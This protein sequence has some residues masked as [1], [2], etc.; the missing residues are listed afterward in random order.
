M[1]K[2]RLQNKKSDLVLSGELNLLTGLADKYVTFFQVYLQ[3]LF[4]G[5][6]WQCCQWVCLGVRYRCALSPFTCPAPHAQVTAANGR[7]LVVGA[8]WVQGPS[9]CLFVC[10][11]SSLLPSA[12]LEKKRQSKGQSNPARRRGD[13]RG[14]PGEW[15]RHCAMFF[16]LSGVWCQSCAV[17]ECQGGVS[18]ANNLGKR[19]DTT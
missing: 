19:Q 17:P 12:V 15:E 5:V 2:L 13:E 1:L 6:R 7:H 16:L 18:S 14:G 4:F 8:W 3:V 10:L 11:F 9:W